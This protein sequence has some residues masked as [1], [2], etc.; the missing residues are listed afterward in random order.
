MPDR[1]RKPGRQRGGAGASAA[2]IE[3][4]GSGACR[5]CQGVGRPKWIVLQNRA[6]SSPGRN[7]GTEAEAWQAAWR[8]PGASAAG[9]VR[10]GP[11]ACRDC[12]RGWEPEWIVLQ[13]RVVLRNRAP[14]PPRCRRRPREAESGSR[15]PPKPARVPRAEALD[16][17]W[18][19]WGAREYHFRLV[20]LHVALEQGARVQVEKFHLRFSLTMPAHKACSTRFE[21]FPTRSIAPFGSGPDVNSAR[22]DWVH[23]WGAV[24]GGQG[25]P[26]SPGRAMR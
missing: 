25:A 17:G 26:A 9:I 2:G 21:R 11:G 13:R 8:A 18:W 23:G 20:L 3:R 1:Q 19:C 5:N 15:A 14:T 12:Q 10:S 4:S 22:R 24:A 7:R 6:S 16:T